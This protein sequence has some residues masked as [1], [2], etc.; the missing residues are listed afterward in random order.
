MTQH[1][2]DIF[3]G[4]SSTNTIAAP[5]TSVAHEISIRDALRISV[6]ELALSTLFCDATA[7]RHDSSFAGLSMCIA[8]VSA[9]RCLFE[10]G[11]PIHYDPTC[12]FMLRNP[13]QARVAGATHLVVVNMDCR[14][15]CRVQSSSPSPRAEPRT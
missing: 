2:G 14:R 10:M 9:S 4:G 3:N 6:P 7:L 12:P 5:P 15:Q 13:T 11:D 1:A 8:A